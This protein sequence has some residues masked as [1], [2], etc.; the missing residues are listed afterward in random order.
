MDALPDRPLSLLNLLHGAFLCEIAAEPVTIHRNEGRQHRCARRSDHL[1]VEHSCHVRAH[2]PHEH[3][4]LA[5]QLN[6]RGK[7]EG[8]IVAQVLSE[9]HPPSLLELLAREVHV[10]PVELL[11]V[12]EAPLQRA[13][14]VV[15]REQHGAHAV[16]LLQLLELREVHPPRVAVAVA[17]ALHPL[18]RAVPREHRIERPRLV[19]LPVTTVPSAHVDR[20][21]RRRCVRRIAAAVRARAVADDL[22]VRA[23]VLEHV[24]RR[25]SEYLSDARDCQVLQ[26]RRLH[27][28]RI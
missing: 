13:V 11:L 7:G 15:R 10:H 22:E 19:P 5:K 14:G 26:H 6:R 18:L 28:P 9:L 8:Y 1:V 3:I 17:G 2:V 12:V 24:V 27:L 25:L 16:P 20:R 4:S 23:H 21:D